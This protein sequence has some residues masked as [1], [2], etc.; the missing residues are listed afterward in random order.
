M[1]R[2]SAKLK[3]EILTAIAHENRI[4][5]VEY[6]ADGPKCACEIAPALKLEQSNL[7]RHMKILIQ[8]GIINY[9]R[10]GKKAMYEISDRNI[11]RIF[12]RVSKVL[13]NRVMDRMKVLNIER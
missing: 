13:K 12:E 4:R 10:D 7:S 2:D 8:A 6:L 5:I 3:S 1:K 9:W 11:L